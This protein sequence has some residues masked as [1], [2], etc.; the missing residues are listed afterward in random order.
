M[1][2]P[3]QILL[4]QRTRS[5]CFTLWNG[6]ISKF[7]ESRELEKNCLV[8]GI[9]FFFTLIWHAQYRLQCK[10]PFHS[11]FVEKGKNIKGKICLPGFFFNF[12]VYFSSVSHIFLPFPS[13]LLLTPSLLPLIFCLYVCRV[14]TSFQPQLFQDF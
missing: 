8:R 1:T 10:C 4:Q 11:G 13:P 6:N 5:V 9:Y 7:M 2:S 3:L 12:S 14:K